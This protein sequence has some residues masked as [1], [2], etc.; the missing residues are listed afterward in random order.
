MIKPY[1]ISLDQVKTFL[2]ITDTTYDP[3]INTYI[4]IVSDDLIRTNGICNQDFLFTGSADTDATTKLSNVSLTSSEWA[5]L[6][7]GSVILINDEDGVIASYDQDAEEIILET[8]LTKTA[9]AEDL[10][11]RNFPYGA[12]PV[13]SQMVLWKINQGSLTG[14]TFGEEISSKSIGTVR[15]QYAGKDNNTNGLGYPVSLI[16]ELATIRRPRFH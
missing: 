8:A 5:G 6:Y 1:V 11:I 3:S 4:P 14:A 7:V 9:T 12:K 2:G 13:V 16:K 10:E 15:I